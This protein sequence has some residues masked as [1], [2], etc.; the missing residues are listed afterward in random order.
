MTHNRHRRIALV[1]AAAA[2]ALT[3]ATAMAAA[4]TPFGARER[5]PLI[6]R[7]AP[8]PVDEPGGAQ[9]LT[10]DQTAL[11]RDSLASGPAKNVILVI[12]DGMGD[13]E[14][15]IARNYL[16]GAGGFFDGLDALP[17]TGQMTHYS[18]NRET[19]LP[20][21]SPD[22][23]ATGTAWATG[24]KTYDNGVS[25]DR[26]GTAYPTILEL[27][28][29][30]GRA[31]GN[32]TTSEI[33]DATPAVLVSHISSRRCYGPVATTATCP[34]AALENGG[35][36]SISEQLLDTRPDVTLGGGA[37]SFAETATAGDWAGLTLAEQAEERGYQYLTDPADLSSVT[38]AD[39]RRPL[40][41]LF[42]AGNLPVRFAP[43]VATP[44]GADG[45]AA[46]CAPEPAFEGVPT[47]AEM[48]DTAID[49]LSRSRSG[50]RHGFFLQV[51]SASIDKKDHAA[52][53]CG[54]IGE[55]EQV[56]EAISAALRFA[57][58]R[59]DTL[60]LVTADHAHTSQIVDAPTPGL[61]EKL[62]TADGAEMYVAYGT[63]AAGGS[64]QHTGTQVRVAGYGPG[65]A[66][67]V[68]LIDQTDLFTIMRR[69]MRVR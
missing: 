23:A 59:G 41:G 38:R 40:L 25:V 49:L 54:Q 65:A 52:D 36:G 2:T 4:S 58:R 19:G 16:E 12:G 22:S 44:T 35:P 20:D 56:D 26:H 9:R 21:Y 3:V 42:A 7:T 69:A 11:I 48:T 15:T 33:Q 6:E 24:V 66:N 14:I 62:L 39:Q 1:A 37:A 28:K 68:G 64:Q 61:N 34:E 31:T 27:A 13:S 45:S 63:S 18:V 50:R 17:L 51:E 5:L 57:A 46:T 32:V 43:L 47:L 60:V 10:G 53:V 29:E 55:T 67:V 8:G 30:Q